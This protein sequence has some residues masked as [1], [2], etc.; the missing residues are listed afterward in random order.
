MKRPDFPL[1]E[2]PNVFNWVQVR[3]H[4]R[5]WLH[6]VNTILVEKVLCDSC[7]MGGGIVLLKGGVPV[8]CKKRDHMRPEHFGDV[9]EGSEVAVDEDE[10]RPVRAPHTMTLRRS[11]TALT[12]FGANRSCALLNT[13][14]LPS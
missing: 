14:R 5:P 1:H 10:G 13:L 7:P 9:T 3:A 6:N 11:P 4:R 12:Q 2:V 8:S